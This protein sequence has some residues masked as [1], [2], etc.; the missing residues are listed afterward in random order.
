MTY[1]EQLAKF[2]AN[3]DYVQLPNSAVNYAKMLMLDSFGVAIAAHDQEVVKNA[4]Q[5]AVSMPHSAGKI[6]LWGSKDKFVNV[7]FA[8]LAN[9]MASHALDYDDTHTES[10]LHGSA[11]FTP[12]VLGLGEELNKTPK[13]VITAFIAAW[14]VAARVG[15]ASKSS[16]HLRGFHSTAIAGYFGAVTAACKLYDLTEQQIV[17]ALG[18]CVSQASGTIEFLSNGSSSKA[19]HVGWAAHGA[20]IN[21]NLAKNNLTG[22]LT[23]FEGTNGIFHTHGLDEK[24]DL[25]QLVAGLGTHWQVEC[26]SIKPYPCCHF[27]HGF[28]D[29]AKALRDEGIK[30]EQIKEII[31]KVDKVPIGFICNPLATKQTPQSSY[32]AKFSLPFVISMMLLD[33][34]LDLSAFKSEQ[35]SREDTLELNKKI[36]Y[37]QA[38]EGETA[39]PKYFPGNLKVICQDGQ[40][41]IKSQEINRGNPDNPLSKAEV[42]AKFTQNSEPFLSAEQ[43]KNCIDF[44]TNLEKKSQINI[45][46]LC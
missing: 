12:L 45:S 22:P 13:Q 4:Q 10:I 2:I 39:F 27:A 20:I 24:A 38:K 16:F 17:N 30:P 25:E 32:A 35:L 31:C 42:V 9:G 7:H 36:S 19:F 44:F 18:L 3:L 21:A 6:K 33:D 40:E 41:I 23:P 8:T 14:E 28:V 11:I 5:A 34:K 29:C 26:V 43:L 1:S 15:I 46:Q 37:I